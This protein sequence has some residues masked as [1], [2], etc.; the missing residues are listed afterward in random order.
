MNHFIVTLAKGSAVLDIY[1]S[2]VHRYNTTS[3]SLPPVYSELWCRMQAVL[4]PTH[5]Y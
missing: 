1:L 5:G 4:G 2:L 3:P